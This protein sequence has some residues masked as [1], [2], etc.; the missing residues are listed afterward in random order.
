[1]AIA[2]IYLATGL[3]WAGR[4]LLEFARP[5]YYDPVTTLDFVAVWSFSCALGLLAVAV[6]LL[7]RDADAGRL[8]MVVAIVTG[9]SSALAAVANGIEDGIGLAAFA[10]LYVPAVLAALV[11]LILTALLL[12]REGRRRAATVAG[13]WC[14]IAGLSFGFGVLVLVGS[15]LAVRDRA[16]LARVHEPTLPP[17]SR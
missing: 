2:A 5:A 1:M 6:P 7:A 8:T 11:A 9:S 10:S 17:R 12:A 14:A 16:A 13:L 15:A 4:T 3:T